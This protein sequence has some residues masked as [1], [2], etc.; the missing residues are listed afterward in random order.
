MIMGIAM[1]AMALMQSL[2][3]GQQAAAENARE[4][5]QFEE[6]EF[7]R[8]MQNQ[9]KNR[10]IANANAAKWMQNIKIGEAASKAEGEQRFW[11]RYNFDNATGQFSRQ[12]R[13]VNDSLS[14]N[15]AQRNINPNSGTAQALL[16][17]SLK[18]AKTGLTDRGIKLSNSLVSAERK[19]EGML[20]QR[21]FGYQN[22]EAFIPGQLIQ[23]SDSSIMQGALVGGILAGVSTGLATSAQQ[24]FAADQQAH[25]QGI[26]SELKIQNDIMDWGS[27]GWF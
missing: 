24:Q 8:Q 3:G 17:Q 4:R 16:Q 20:A 15:F 1:G 18:T 12:Y 9:I 19:K 5:A 21:D 14:R 22:Q 26:L 25:Q 2:Q 6:Q 27:G 7:Q 10:N 13:K 11:M 23:Q